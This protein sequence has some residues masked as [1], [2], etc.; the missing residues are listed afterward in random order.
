[1]KFISGDFEVLTCMYECVFWKPRIAIDLMMRYLYK[2]RNE[3]SLFQMILITNLAKRAV[4]ARRDSFPSNF[5]G[6]CMRNY[7][8]KRNFFR[9]MVNSTCELVVEDGSNRVLSAVC[10]DL[11][12]TGMSLEVDE[13]ISEQTLMSASIEAPGTQ[14]PTLT[15]KVKVVRCAP[16]S[17]DNFVLGVE[18][19][20]MN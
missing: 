1:M 6:R 3:D 19:V 15:A 2:V 5:E 13:A 20:E 9:M 17:D 11:S 18:I 4:T 10:K 12:A 16:A 14:I 7:D 8:D